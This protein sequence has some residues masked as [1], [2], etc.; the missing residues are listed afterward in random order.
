M[1]CLLP[2]I[3]WM[4]VYWL[5]VCSSRLSWLLLNKVSLKFFNFLKSEL[6]PVFFMSLLKLDFRNYLGSLLFKLK[7][8]NLSTLFL[9]PGLPERMRSLPLAKLGREDTDSSI[10]F[11]PTKFMSFCYILPA[12]STYV[13]Y[14]TL[15]WWMASVGERSL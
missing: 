2:S 9:F 12:L 6:R 15:F 13:I 3:Y 11:R 10:S 4:V 1:V 7:F 5:M 8:I 14:F